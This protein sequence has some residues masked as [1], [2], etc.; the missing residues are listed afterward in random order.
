MIWLLPGPI[1]NKFFKW[2]CF[3][4]LEHVN[5]LNIKKITGK[6]IIVNFDHGTNKEK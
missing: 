6:K 4:V 2:A 5:K 1:V 3:S